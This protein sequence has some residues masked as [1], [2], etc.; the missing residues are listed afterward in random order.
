MRPQF[1]RG[2][3]LVAVINDRPVV[4][5]EQNQ[6]VIG[7]VVLVQR[8]QNLAHTPI[9]FRDGIPARPHRRLADEALVRDARH[10]DIVGGEIQEERLGL[11][12]INE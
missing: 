7:Q 5:G 6:R 10:V 2:L 11:V 12:E 3:V 8:L 9:Q 4:A 1:L